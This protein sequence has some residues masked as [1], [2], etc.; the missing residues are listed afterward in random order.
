LGNREREKGDEMLGKM[1]AGVLL[2]VGVVCGDVIGDAKSAYDREDY[3][4][5]FKLF[6]KV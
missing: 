3:K 6:Q 1:L 5:A 2:M 4:T